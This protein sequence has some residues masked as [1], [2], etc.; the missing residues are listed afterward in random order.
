VCP[1]NSA[2]PAGSGFIT[3]CLCNGGVTGPNGGPCAPCA[4][5]MYKVSVSGW[6]SN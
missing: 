4:A 1:A 2:A 6:C 5:G 3:N